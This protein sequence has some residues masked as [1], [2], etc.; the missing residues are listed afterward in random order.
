MKQLLK[1]ILYQSKKSQNLA[2]IMIL[3]CMISCNVQNQTKSDDKANIESPSKRFSIEESK[4]IVLPKNGFYCG[5]LDSE[6]EMWFG[7][8]GGGLYRYDGE[9]FIRYI[10]GDGRID[11]KFLAIIEDKENNLWFGTANGLWKYDR[12][13]FTHVPI[14]FSDTSG[15]WLEKVYHVLSPNAVHSLEVDDSG[16]IWIGTGGAGAYRYD[17]ISF[18]SHLSEVGNKQIDSLYH[19]WIPSIEKDSEGNIWFASMC[20]G[21]VSRYKEGEFTHFTIKDGLSDDMIR[22]IFSDKSGN[23][24]IGSNGNRKSALTFYNGESFKTYTKED[25]LCNNQVWSIYEDK[26]SNLWLSSQRGNL[27]VFDGETFSEFTTPNG[28]TFSGILFI[29]ED[30]NNNIWF[31]GK[32]GLRKFDGKSVSALIK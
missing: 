4:N 28:E 2:I 29:L 26:D 20:H 9:D 19:N 14:P 12:E 32:D 1:S 3:F 13:V 24:W 30:S 17:G 8:N 31:G 23:I 22:S 16:N 10:E 5:I 15:V 25:G 27:C 11:N 21:G 7:S 6:G 18:T